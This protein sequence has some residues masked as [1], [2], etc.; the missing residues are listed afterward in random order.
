MAWAVVGP[1]DYVELAGSEEWGRDDESWFRHLWNQST[2]P[3]SIMK[4][5]WKIWTL[6][7]EWTSLSSRHVVQLLNQCST[8]WDLVDC[9]APGF[10]VVCPARQ[11]ATRGVLCVVTQEFCRL[12]CPRNNESFTSGIWPDSVLRLVLIYPFPVISHTHEYES[13]WWVIWVL[14]ANYGNWVWFWELLNVQVLEILGRLYTLEDCTL[15]SC[16]LAN[17]G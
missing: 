6:K 10:P 16:C 11:S 4:P 9:S 8:L 7:M 17:S 15:L 2:N 1:L 3:A 13:S 14:L 5:Q 12:T